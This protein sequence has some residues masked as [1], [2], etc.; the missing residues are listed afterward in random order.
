[1][2]NIYTIIFIIIPISMF[3]AGFLVARQLRGL[4]KVP[5]FSM[6]FIQRRLLFS[7]VMG[8]F[9]SLTFMAILGLVDGF[10]SQLF[11]SFFG[12][13]LLAT[14][15]YYFGVSFG[16]GKSESSDESIPTAIS[17]AETETSF[18][19]NIVVENSLASVKITINSKKRW[20]LFAM[21]AFQLVF[22]G[23]C[24]LPILSLLAISFLQNYL[25]QNFRFLVWLLVGGLA[26]YLLYTKVMEAL[27]Y[28]FDKEIVEINNLSV[29]IEK[30][31]SKFSNK[32]EYPAENIK[33]ITRMFSFGSTNTVLK[34]SPFVN[35][36]MPAFMM[37]HNRGLKRYRAFGRAVDLADA[38]RILEIVCAK[39]PQYKG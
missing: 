14:F 11:L 5:L 29:R 21:E 32:K 1:M 38:Q 39:F 15:S 4:E 24:G 18:P 20:G 2:D 28:I 35:S 6:M 17:Q 26:L 36:N 7:I 3:G 27:E 33:K 31:G 9:I 16:W 10:T 23:L 13:F 8:F 12:I 30:Y 37:W 34:R 25:P 22:I 19:E